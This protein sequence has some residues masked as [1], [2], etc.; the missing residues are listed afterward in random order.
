MRLVALLAPFA[1]A[2]CSE[3]VAQGGAAARP[4]RPVQLV[5]AGTAELPTKVAV[6]GVLAAQEELVLGLEVAGRLA[7]LPVDVGDVVQAGTV[8][9]TLAPREFELEIERAQAAVVAAEARLGVAADGDLERF[10]VERAPA[11]SEAAAVVT[12][13]RLNR[14]R[15]ATM[16]EGQMQPGSALET[17]VATLA[18]AESRLQKA[19]DDV[20][21]WLAEARL[22]RVELRQ[23]Q[24]RR[25]DSVIAAPWTGRIAQR[26][27]VAGQ[28]LAS[29]GPVVTLL[30]IDPLRL[31]LRVPDRAA[32]AIAAG[33]AVEFTVD[34]LGDEVF[35]GRVVRTG[36]AIERGDRTRLVEAE[37]PNAEA[38][39]LPGAFCRAQI[40]TAAAVPVV[41]VPRTAVVSFAGVDRVFTVG[42][43]E[44]PKGGSA[45]RGGTGGKDAVA[46]PANG[47]G[48]AAPSATPAAG[49]GKVAKGRIVELGRAVGDQVE[50]VRGLE[51]GTSIVRDATG[52]GPETPVAV[53]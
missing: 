53:E 11:V 32:M 31:R 2:A 8:V 18:V 16:V 23:A 40:V 47:G 41:V 24:K 6:T 43:P 45:G 29:G 15:I 5:V 50:I 20:R 3:R 46:A 21:T 4:P 10:D 49:A 35:R 48:P 42:D 14:E 28:V 39:L 12:E 1:L 27:A 19:R 25:A 33:Q 51:V 26:H 52:L 30:R 44:P 22:R 37:V 7:T 38:T 36:P 9:A 13:A 34:G 17:A